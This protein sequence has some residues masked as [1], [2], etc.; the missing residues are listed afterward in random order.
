MIMVEKH[1]PSHRAPSGLSKWAVSLIS[2]G[3][4]LILISGALLF[5]IKM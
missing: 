3:V 2:F 1:P 4:T 5:L